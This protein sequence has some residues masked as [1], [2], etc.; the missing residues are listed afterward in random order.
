MMATA[1]AMSAVRANRRLLSK[2]TWLMVKVP[3]RPS[4]VIVY[5]LASVAVNAKIT[6]AESPPPKVIVLTVLTIPL[7][8]KETSNDPSR[9]PMFFARNETSNSLPNS[10]F[11]GINRLENT[12]SAGVG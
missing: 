8:F 7:T 6:S 2:G 1:E 5:V 12:N 4:T 10:T 9:S 11:S 3:S